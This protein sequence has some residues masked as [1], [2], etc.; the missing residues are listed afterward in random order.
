MY[1]GVENGVRNELNMESESESS[2][3]VDSSYG[4]RIS[5]KASWIEW[6]AWKRRMNLR[7]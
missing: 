1:I 7:E 3:M 4:T 2:A 5:S 6:M